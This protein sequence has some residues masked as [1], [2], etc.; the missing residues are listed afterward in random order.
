ME[1]DKRNLT[2]FG[3]GGTLFG[4]HLVN[5]FLGLITLGI[6]FFWARVKVRKYIWGQLEF[7]GDRL[8]YHGTGLETLKG[9]LKAMV[10]FGI[11]YFVVSQLPRLMGL[12]RVLVI[13]GGLF[14]VLLIMVFIPM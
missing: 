4:I 3:N 13:L 5:L 2:F 9:W 10:V 11:P 7:E 6:Y 14:S 8:S 12:G 1:N